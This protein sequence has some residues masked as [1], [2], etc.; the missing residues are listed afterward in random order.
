MAHQDARGLKYVI[1]DW[2]LLQVILFNLE[3]VTQ[4]FIVVK[5]TQVTILTSFMC[6]VQWHKYIHIVVQPSPYPASELFHLSNLKLYI[7]KQ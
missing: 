4:F 2:T 7:I 1:T 6:T 5:Y 3:R